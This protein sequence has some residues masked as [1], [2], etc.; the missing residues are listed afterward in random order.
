MEHHRRHLFMDLQMTSRLLRIAHPLNLQTCCIGVTKCPQLSSTIFF[1]YGLHVIQTAHL[2]V[3]LTTCT[4]ALMRQQLGV[5]HGNHSLWCIKMRLKPSHRHLGRPQSMRF[6]SMTLM[7]WSK[8]NLPILTLPMRWISHRNV[9]LTDKEDVG[10]KISCLG[11]GLG[12]R[13]YVLMSH[14]FYSTSFYWL[15]L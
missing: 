9:S 1:K 6:F 5:F 3:T 4:A 7:K 10:T 2:S 14:L 15:K 8:I 13:R 12:G 11:I